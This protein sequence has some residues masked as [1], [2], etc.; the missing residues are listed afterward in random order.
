MDK[1]S[2][3]SNQP[4]KIGEARIYR[5]RMTQRILFLYAV[6][7][8]ALILYLRTSESMDA[9]KIETSSTPHQVKQQTLEWV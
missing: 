8:A 7:N 6:H 2:E 4:D 9:E 5:H 1:I 3:T